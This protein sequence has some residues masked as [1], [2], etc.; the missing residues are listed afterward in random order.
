MTEAE[1]KQIK[2]PCA[3]P[4]DTTCF[5]FVSGRYY[6]GMWFMAVPPG[7]EWPFGGNITA[8]CWRYD[9]TLT[10]WIVT[11][12][13]RYYADNSGKAWESGDKKSWWAA[14]LS[15]DEAT[16]EKQVASL[17][18]SLSGLTGLFFITTPPVVHALI[19][20]G[21]SEKALGIIARRKPF[22]MQMKAT[23]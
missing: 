20:K 2:D 8:Q 16:I 5:V 21:D 9:S 10:E 11:Y 17:V 12:R 14:K 6:L 7:K 4:W 1:A 18:D 3:I 15:G 13:F 22:W 23:P 19:F